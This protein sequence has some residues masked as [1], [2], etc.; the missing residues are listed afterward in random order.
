[1]KQKRARINRR[2]FLYAAGT[3]GVAL[4]FL[5]GLPERSAFAQNENPVFGFFICTPHGVVQQYGNEPER[6]WPTQLGALTT[7]GMEGDA[8][9]RCT[10][11]LADYADKLL[12]VRGV[13]YPAPPTGCGH[14]QGLV[15]CLTA[16]VTTGSGNNA[17]S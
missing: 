17:T 16:R 4:P 5:E 7:A 1:M 2:A 3:T 11:L 14:A 10:G 8:S 9:T 13:N 12:I 6:F 15:Q